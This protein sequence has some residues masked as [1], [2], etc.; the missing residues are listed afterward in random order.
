MPPIGQLASKVTPR[1]W[2]IGGG[3]A[4]AGDRVHLPVRAHRLPAD[5]L[6][7]GERARPGPDRQDDRHAQHRGIHYELQNNGTALAVQSNQTAQAR[8][9]LAGAGAARQHAARLRAVRQTE[10]RR[11]QLPAAGHLPARPAGPAR[12]DDRQRP[13]GLRR[14]GRA[15]PAQPAEPGVRRNLERRLGGGAAVGDHLAGSELG[16][17]DRH[18][19]GVQRARAAAQQSDDHRRIWTAAVAGCRRRGR[20]LGFQRPGSRAALRPGHRREPRR[21]ARPD[22]RRRTRRR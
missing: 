16:E 18:A 5:L 1:G 8:V 15:R 14:P 12:A 21:D 19:R 13:G 7:A 9:A 10:S 22:A 6:D 4:A 2:L 20:R 17:G 3:F 11:K